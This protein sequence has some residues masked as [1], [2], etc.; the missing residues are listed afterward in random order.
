MSQPSASGPVPEPTPE[1]FAERARR[2]DKATRSVLAA[3]LCL[4]A[5]TILLVPR[6]IAFTT[7]LGPVRLTIVI[8][9]AVIL[10]AAAGLV[11]R[12]WGIAL[13]SALQLAFFATGI[14]IAT[15]FFIAALFMAVWLRV[16]M[17]RQEV[18]GGPRGFRIL[19]G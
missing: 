9:L 13:G 15:M 7:G 10:V 1:Q 11:R 8:T 14:L 5:L 19:A 16:L 6:A 18:I 4:E 12:P 2:A 17:F 3:V